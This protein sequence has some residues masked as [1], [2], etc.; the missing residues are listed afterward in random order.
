MVSFAVR[1][2][3]YLIDFAIK[4]VSAAESNSTNNHDFL[5]DWIIKSLRSYEHKTFTKVVGAGLPHA[6]Q[7]T[8]PTLC[9]RLWLELDIVPIVIQQHHEHKEMISLW[10]S[11]RVDEQAD[12]MARKCIMYVVYFSGLGT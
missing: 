10:L 3:T 11:K 12:S 7:T 6:L 4:N 9:S 8:S 5:A 2:A 1:D